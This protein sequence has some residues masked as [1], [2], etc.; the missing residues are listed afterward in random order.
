MREHYSI[1]VNYVFKGNDLMKNLNDL[2]E[3][4]NFSE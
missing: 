1:T 2:K 4:E 3:G